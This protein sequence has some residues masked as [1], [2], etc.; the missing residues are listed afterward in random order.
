VRPKMPDIKNS[1]FEMLEYLEVIE[2]CD[3]Q[4][5]WSREDGNIIHKDARY[6]YA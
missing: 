3:E 6:E 4:I 2:L 1:D 5:T